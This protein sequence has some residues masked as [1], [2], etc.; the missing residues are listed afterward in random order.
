[1]R[2]SPQGKSSPHGRITSVNGLA[3]VRLSAASP[4]GK[5]SPLVGSP[6]QHLKETH[7]FII[8]S[9]QGTALVPWYM[10]DLVTT[11]RGPYP[12]SVQRYRTHTQ[13]LGVRG[14]VTRCARGWISRVFHEARKHI[15]GSARPRYSLSFRS[16]CRRSLASPQRNGISAPKI[17]PLKI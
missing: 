10:W 12:H 9:L 14:A 7:R 4:Q 11:E 6:R 3:S 17:E 2:S 13:S 5:A 15:L 8:V 1:M 16:G